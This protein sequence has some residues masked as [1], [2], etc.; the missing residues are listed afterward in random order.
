[1]SSLVGDHMVVQR[2]G[3]VRLAGT[4][5]PGQTVHATLAGGSAAAKTDAAGHWPIALPA[6]DAGGPFDSRSK[7]R[8]P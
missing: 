5:L 6:L 4:D 1:M 7:A 3:P 2:G 8:A